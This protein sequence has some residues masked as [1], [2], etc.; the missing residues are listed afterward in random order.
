M[1]SARRP[2]AKKT[3]KRSQERNRLT[4]KKRN[5]TAQRRAVEM[6]GEKSEAVGEFKP[7]IDRRAGHDVAPVHG[8]RDVFL[9]EKIVDV[10]LGAPVIVNLVAG[11]KVDQRARR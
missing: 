10:E 1:V 9:V 7:R 4:G 2:P 6:V 3:A 11:R 8:R 5:S